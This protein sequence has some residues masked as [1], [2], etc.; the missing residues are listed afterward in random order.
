M[1][2]LFVSTLSC[3]VISAAA[4]G[5]CKSQK[6]ASPAKSVAA[7]PEAQGVR[8]ALFEDA[9][10]AVIAQKAP[11]KADTKPYGCSV[12]YAAGAP[13]A[14]TVASLGQPAP[15]FELQDLSGKTYKLSELKG[16]T[17]VLEWYNPECPFVE[18][19]Y[20][21]GPLK[22]LAEK[23][24][25]NLVWLNINSGAPGKQGTGKELNQKL[26]KELGVKHPVLLDESGNVGRSYGAKTT[27]HMFIIDAKGVLVYRG[28]LDN[29]PFGKIKS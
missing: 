12:K 1:N 21:N 6:S 17:V 10:S 19:A 13:A 24:K 27:P 15:D 14:A 20:N 3:L 25:D 28:A 16:K 22:G 23:S 5:G 8:E 18:H 4:L 2:K 29:A 9:L 7:A 11:A 26:A